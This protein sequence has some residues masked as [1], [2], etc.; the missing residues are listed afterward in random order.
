M[1]PAFRALRLL[2]RTAVPHARR[3]ED[4][5][6]QL[7][8]AVRLASLAL[9][10]GSLVEVYADECFWEARIVRIKKEGMGFHFCFVGAEHETGY[11]RFDAF[12][13]RWRF[14][15]ERHPLADFTAERVGCLLRCA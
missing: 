14:P 8:A 15:L 4:D 12:L 11:V 6:A 10:A 13:E 2:A 9:R 1:R 5:V 7:R 3:D